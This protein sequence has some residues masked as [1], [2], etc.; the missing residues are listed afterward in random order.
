M[1]LLKK[2]QV[3][4]HGYWRGM[5]NRTFNIIWK[6][7]GGGKR[8]SQL[9]FLGLIHLGQITRP[10][11]AVLYVDADTSFSSVDF[12]KLYNA[13]MK[14]SRAGAACGE[15]CVRNQDYRNPLS[16]AQ[17]Y[18]YLINHMLSKSAESWHGIVLCCPGAW[19]MYR[20]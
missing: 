3:L 20:V 4:Y 13:L 12:G 5:H 17:S 7:E 16:L 9:L 2:R 18:E 15:V 11:D 10:R 1:K 8:D 19:C 6:P 14:N